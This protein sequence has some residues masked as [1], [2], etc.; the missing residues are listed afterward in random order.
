M[1]V[2]GTVCLGLGLSGVTAVAADNEPVILKGS[3]L[4]ISVAFS[5]DGKTLASGVSNGTIKLW[6]VTRG[7][8][9]DTLTGYADVSH[10]AFSPDGKTLASGGEVR[11]EKTAVRRTMIKLWDVATGKEQST[12]TPVEKKSLVSS[13]AFSPDGKTL[14]ISTYFIDDSGVKYAGV[15]VLL[16][17]MKTSQVKTTLKGHTSP[18]KSLAFSPD[19]KTLASGGD[20]TVGVWDVATGKELATLKGYVKDSASVAFSPNGKTLALGGRED[21]TIKLWDVATGKEQSTLEGHTAPVMSV[22]FSP[23]GKSLVSSGDTTIRW[24]DIATGKELASH[25]AAV[26]AR[27]FSP[28]CKTLASIGGYDIMLRDVPGR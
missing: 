23:D 8:A 20:T 6:N 27:V 4:V 15:A 12:F 22:A 3:S 13:L 26:V 2:L 7:G 17:D 14:A 28:D 21:K 1:V 16:W 24:W 18:V 19:S 5:P 9:V 10:V 25:K 11:D